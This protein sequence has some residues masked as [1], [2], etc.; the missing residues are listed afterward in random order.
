MSDKKSQIIDTILDFGLI[1]GISFAI[2]FGLT[3]LG[4]PFWLALV[5]VALWGAYTG[6]RPKFIRKIFSFLY[7]R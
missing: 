1:I 3:L 7:P 5:C 4:A 6:Y 2:F